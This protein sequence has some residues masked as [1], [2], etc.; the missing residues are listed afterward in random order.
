MDSQLFATTKPKKSSATRKIPRDPFSALK[1][2]QTI[3]VRLSFPFTLSTSAAGIINPTAFGSSNAQSDPATG[4]TSYAARFNN[5]RVLA[6]RFQLQPL[7]NFASDSALTS[8]LGQL[9]LCEY[10]GSLPP[11]TQAAI[12]NSPS[13]KCFSTG[14]NIKYKI[15]PHSFPNWKFY[16]ATSTGI[17]A[18][19]SYGVALCTNNLVTLPTSQPIFSVLYEWVVEFMGCD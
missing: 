5:Y 19:N 18:E 17:I 14:Q 4:F 9:Y 10:Y 13:L 6:I 15:V 2:N 8:A 1:A 7:F 16:A 12:A 11:S 3:Q